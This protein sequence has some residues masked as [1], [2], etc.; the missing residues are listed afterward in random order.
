M[1]KFQTPDTEHEENWWEIVGLAYFQLW[2][3]NPLAQNL[4]RPWERYSMPEQPSTSASPSVTQRDYSRIIG[5]I[6]TPAEPPKP[7]GKS[8]GGAKGQ[9]QPLR[10]I[11]KIIKKGDRRPKKK[12]A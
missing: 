6:G 8:L 5:Q 2:M 11:T 10:S 1:D 3:A 9:T 12:V 7:R 4:P